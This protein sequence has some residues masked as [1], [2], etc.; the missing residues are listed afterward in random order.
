M[1]S[2]GMKPKVY[3]TP[4][5]ANKLQDELDNLWKVQRPRVTQAVAD[6]AAQGDRSEN[7]D[8]IYGKK[9]L[10]EIDARVRWIQKRL[11]AIVIVERKPEET[12]KVFFG[13][14]VRLRNPDG[15]VVDY[16]LVGPDD[17]DLEKNMITLHSPIGRALKGKKKGEKVKVRLP[18]GDTEFTILDVR[19]EPFA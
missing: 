15:R 10:R 18:R 3:I 19:Y 2:A 6:A 17:L 4:E 13:A 16:R 12:D 7:A 11:D 8:Y 1:F 5:G 9:K 14:Y